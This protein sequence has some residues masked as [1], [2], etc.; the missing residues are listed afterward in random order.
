MKPR[1]KKMKKVIFIVSMLGL[2]WGCKKEK[3]EPVMPDGLT[4][5]TNF[6]NPVYVQKKLTN[7]GGALERFERI[8]FKY[9][10]D[11]LLKNVTSLFSL[12]SVK[13]DTLVK[14]QYNYNNGKYSS[15]EAI[16]NYGTVNGYGYTLFLDRKIMKYSYNYKDGRVN[17]VSETIIN[18][19][20]NNKEFKM[21]YNNSSFVG[22]VSQRDSFVLASSVGYKNYIFNQYRLGYFGDTL[23]YVKQLDYTYINDPKGD[24]L[25]PVYLEMKHTFQNE[26]WAFISY[27]TAMAIPFHSTFTYSLD[28]PSKSLMQSTNTALRYGIGEEYE[29]SFNSNNLLVSF[30]SWFKD[31]FSVRKEKKL[32][33]IIIQY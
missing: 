8:Y 22:F 33:Q 28:E 14:A 12:D 7:Y 16:W 26:V 4:S 18:S 5:K 23:K 15:T 31:A 29:Y 20:E 21:L 19:V 30:Q 24:Y 2:L 1:F 6:I 27:G 3:I 9:Y 17:S 13:W 32:A 10:D 11:G 25:E